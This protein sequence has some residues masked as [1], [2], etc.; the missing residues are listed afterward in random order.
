VVTLDG[1]P[2][3]ATVVGVGTTCV[4]GLIASFDDRYARFGPGSIVVEH[5]IKWAFEQRLNVDFGVG[6]ERF[7]AYWSRNNITGAWSAQI[8]NSRW[9]VFAFRSKKTVRA[10][11]RRMARLSGLS[12]GQ[13]RGA[14][15]FVPDNHDNPDS[16]RGLDLPMNPS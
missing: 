10:A 13:R 14:S 15:A 16:V 12:G 9:G 4:D 7:K 8:A 11:A 6:A 5:V 3:A 1:A 2:V